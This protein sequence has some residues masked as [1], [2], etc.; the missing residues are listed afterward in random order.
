[1]LR[2][3][4]PHL[5]SPRQRHPPSPASSHGGAPSA[6]PHSFPPALRFPWIGS[7]IHLGTLAIRLVSL[8]LSCRGAATLSALHHRLHWGENSAINFH[9]CEPSVGLGI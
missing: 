8:T 6:L 7:A 3:R 5:H 2:C 4:Q 1:V 9:Q